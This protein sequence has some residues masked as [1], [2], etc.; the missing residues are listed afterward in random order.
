MVS[1]QAQHEAN[2]VIEYYQQLTMPCSSQDDLAWVFA[3]W[4]VHQFEQRELTEKDLDTARKIIR[5]IPTG[6]QRLYR[7]A[8]NHI[9]VYLKEACHWVLPR[10]DSIS[11]HLDDH[12]IQW[13]T[14]LTNQAS[15][16]HQ[17]H[18]HYQQLK[19]DFFT[20]RPSIDTVFITLMIGFEVAPLSLKHIGQILNDPTSIEQNGVATRLTVRHL[21]H[22]DVDASFTHYHLSLFCYRLL[23]DY[24]AAAPPSITDNA[25][26][27]RCE[28]WAQTYHLP[29]ARANQWQQRFQITWFIIHKLPPSLLKDLSYPE[30]HVGFIPVTDNTHIKSA[31]KVR[32]IYDI[33]WDLNWFDKL[34]TS[35]KK[36]NWPHKQLL[37]H[38]VKDHSAKSSVTQQ[39][40]RYIDWAL[41]PQWDA[42]NIL[43]RMLFLYTAQLIEYGG[44][45]KERLAPSS[46]VKY[47]TLDKTL[48]NFPLSYVEATSEVDLNLWAKTVY[49]SL[50]TDSTQLTMY[51]FLRFISVQELTESLDMSALT[52]PTNRPSVNAYRL[53]LDDFEHLFDALIN[54]P[55]NNPFR[56][57]YAALAAILGF[58]GMLRRGE[59]LRLRFQDITF[60][61]SK[62]ALSLCITATEEGHTK[63][64]NTRM[65]HTVLPK[66]FISFLCT[67]LS[68]KKALPPDSPLIGFEGEKYHS[69]QLFYVLPVS[70]AL[71]A[72]FGEQVNFHHLRHSGVHLFMLQGLHLANQTREISRGKTELETVMLSDNTLATRF[73]YWLNGREITLVNDGILLD[74]MGMQI[75]HAHYAT[76]R[77]S[78]LHGVDWLLPIITKRYSLDLQQAYSHAELRYLFGLKNQSN[79]LSSRLHKIMW[80]RQYKALNEKQ[81]NP[82]LLEETEIRASL[83]LPAEKTKK[84]KEQSE[85]MSAY[86]TWEKSVASN[87][88][89]LLGY[90]FHSMHE[91]KI[92]DLQGLSAIWKL[93]CQHHIAAITKKQ[94]TALRLLPPIK[95]NVE[96]NTLYFTPDCNLKHAKAYRE[97]FHHKDW[98]WLTFDFELAVNR[99]V[100]PARK[101]KILKD[102]FMQSKDTLRITKHPEGDTLLTVTLR[103]KDGISDL[104]LDTAHQCLLS[105][106]HD[107]DNL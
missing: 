101:E 48:L 8:L 66:Q 62:G 105:I 99:K 56:S 81:A 14:P 79:A 98:Q 18:E 82:V 52:P 74:E 38:I 90:L 20:Q 95:R 31:T 32:T 65:V 100:R 94:K 19:C 22:K 54:A 2:K 44:V 55:T 9:V 29:K 77:W 78:Y 104:I 102:E 67:T 25:L 6:K 63:S 13:F 80:D 89:S 68:M 34:K 10:Q 72:L 92:I 3:H 17:W 70:K 75:G 83:F 96:D 84:P 85:D 87:D 91:A 39:K 103:P 36:A 64:G 53:S 61:P 5:E 33:D 71:K 7:Q 35:T 41:E 4:P 21:Q 58:F 26:F 57:L 1:N 42:H 86:C 49:Q 69:R 46:I 40:A 15:S 30:R 45:K 107:K 12:N 97:I 43:P 59:V 11:T 60:D 76:T 23:C 50:S 106:Q 27:K 73:R 24:Y 93:G 16:A 28:Q 88:H 47:T 37:N 51:Y